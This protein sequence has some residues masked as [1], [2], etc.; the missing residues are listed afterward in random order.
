QIH[1]D[2]PQ[3][4]LDRLI[5]SQHG[6]ATKIKALQQ[7]R[8]HCDPFELAAHIERQLER[9]W[10]LSNPKQKPHVTKNHR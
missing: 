1:H 8:S 10:D 4:P 6:D 3:T 9:L 7:L 5:T 2:T